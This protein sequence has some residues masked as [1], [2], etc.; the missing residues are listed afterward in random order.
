MALLKTPIL[1]VVDQTTWYS[2]WITWHLRNAF[3]G[4]HNILESAA[5]FCSW[6]YL[7]WVFTFPWSAASYTKDL[8]SWMYP[9]WPEFIPD[10]LWRMMEKEAFPSKLTI[11]S[12]EMRD[13]T[14]V[15]LVAETQHV[16]LLW[17]KV[18]IIIEQLPWRSKNLSIFI[19]WP[20]RLYFWHW[21]IIGGTYPTFGAILCPL[22]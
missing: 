6:F 14:P 19:R 13:N 12:W 3:N 20:L 1:I 7:T 2:P 10:M 9:T 5:S 21:N 8:S 4:W 22:F 15:R 16:N 11:S 18:R 17:M